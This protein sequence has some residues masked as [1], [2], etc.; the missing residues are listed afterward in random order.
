MG[1]EKIEITNHVEYERGLAALDKVMTAANNN[2]PLP[3]SVVAEL[4]ELVTA[5]E[6]YEKQHFPIP[7]PTRADWEA[8]QREERRLV[9]VPYPEDDK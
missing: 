8:F 7:Q 1:S 9:P 3:L 2:R 5:L 6:V 4:N